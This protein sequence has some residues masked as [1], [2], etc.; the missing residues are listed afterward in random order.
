MLWTLAIECIAQHVGCRQS[1]F[2]ILPGAGRYQIAHI[3]VTNGG[4]FLRDTAIDFKRNEC[5]VRWKYSGNVT[6]TGFAR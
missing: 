1:I 3:G 5:R 6:P 2:A 4:R